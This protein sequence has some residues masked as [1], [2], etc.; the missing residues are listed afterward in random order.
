MKTQELVKIVSAYPREK[1]NE[2]SLYCVELQGKRSLSM[3]ALGCA[4]AVRFEVSKIEG[5][6]LAHAFNRYIL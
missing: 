6:K 4:I 3:Y 1:R 5:I 2:I